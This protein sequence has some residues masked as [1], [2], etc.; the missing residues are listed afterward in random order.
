[1]FAHGLTNVKLNLDPPPAKIP[2][3]V[4]SDDSF[5]THITVWLTPSLITQLKALVKDLPE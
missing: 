4:F 3:I 2:N 5:S 1:M